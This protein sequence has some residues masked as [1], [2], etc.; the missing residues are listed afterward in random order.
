MQQCS[1]N[2]STKL[3][4]NILLNINID[5]NISYVI[6]LYILKVLF[7]GMLF[8]FHL[9]KI[10]YKYLYLSTLVQHLVQRWI[11]KEQIP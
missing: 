10:L 8:Y 1:I 3:T 11:I 4:N 7:E 6:L 9:S 5:P 2:Y